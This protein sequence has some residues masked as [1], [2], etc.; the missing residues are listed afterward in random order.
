[1]SVKLTGAKELTV[2]LTKK[3][4]LNAVKTV[5]KV[6]GS[7]LQQKAMQNAPVATGTLKRSISLQIQDGGM[8]AKAE[9]TA[10]YAPY[11]EYG[12]RYMEPH[13]FM[14]PAFQVQKEQFKSDLK[15]LMR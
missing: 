6:N 8:T 10:E 7:R 15:K 4:N 9:A 5:I 11:Q 3:T 12:T 13:P 1:M 2:A 14:D